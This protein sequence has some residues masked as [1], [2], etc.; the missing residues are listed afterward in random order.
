MRDSSALVLL[1]AWRGDNPSSIP[2]AARS[3]DVEGF[4]CESG[5]WDE[6]SLHEWTAFNGSERNATAYRRLMV[7]AVTKAG[8][9]AI[10]YYSLL[11]TPYSLLPTP[12]SLLPTPYSP[13]TTP[14]SLLTT[15]Y[16]TRTCVY[17]TRATTASATPA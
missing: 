16:V 8:R 17:R 2:T 6:A 13:L 3:L 10:A 15:H 4:T 7:F 5:T 12:Y 14:H 9:H 11:P 1:P